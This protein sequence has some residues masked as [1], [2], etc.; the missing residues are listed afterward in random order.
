MRRENQRDP[1]VIGCKKEENYQEET[2]KRQK[3]EIFS[4][5]SKEFRDENRRNGVT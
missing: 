3:A 2:K 1:T 4:L 5:F